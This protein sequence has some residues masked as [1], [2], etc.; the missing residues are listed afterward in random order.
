M[1]SEWVLLRA[2]NSR[3]QRQALGSLRQHRLYSFVEDLHCLCVVHACVLVIS[4]I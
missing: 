4:I 1:C 2:A 3:K